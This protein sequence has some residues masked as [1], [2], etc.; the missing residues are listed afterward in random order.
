MDKSLSERTRCGHKHDNNK[1][2]LLVKS[3]KTPLSA[4]KK[5]GKSALARLLCGTLAVPPLTVKRVTRY[6][7]TIRHPTMHR[8]YAR[9]IALPHPTIH[10]ETENLMVKAT[11]LIGGPG[12]AARRA[13]R[14]MGE[15]RHDIMAIF[16]EAAA[17]DK[18]SLH[19][20]RPRVYT[21]PGG[22]STAHTLRRCLTGKFSLAA[23]FSLSDSQC[24]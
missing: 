2:G 16:S 11:R 17:A 4:V 10:R 22:G 21:Q 6:S 13:L 9:L 23:R 15:P 3:F 18:V 20:V 7:K 12:L 1:F 8:F 5:K 14:P 24:G 19:A